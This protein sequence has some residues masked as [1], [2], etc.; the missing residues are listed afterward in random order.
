MNN[1]QFT[2]NECGNDWNDC[3]C[4]TQIPLLK[5][6]IEY[7]QKRAI[8]LAMDNGRLAAEK[9]TLRDE[10]AKLREIC[11]DKLIGT[12]ESMGLHIEDYLKTLKPEYRP[13]MTEVVYKMCREEEQS[14]F[15][16]C[17]KQQARIAELEAEN[18][19]LLK[20]RNEHKQYLDRV[21][22]SLIEFFDDPDVKR[23]ATELWDKAM[24]AP[25][26]WD[27]PEAQP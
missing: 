22:R 6:R 12:L 4:S 19:E 24:N 5:A 15:D 20:S 21:M 27:K 16:L 11:R 10:N 26:K 9:Y 2:C 25:D 3:E 14:V 1:R 8:L 13:T 23:E 18:T 7:L 17:V